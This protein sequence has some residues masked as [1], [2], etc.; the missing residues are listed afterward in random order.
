MQD[1]LPQESY[2]GRSIRDIPVSSNRRTPILGM[3]SQPPRR[4]GGSSVVTKIIRSSLCA[5]ILAA[6][7]ASFFSGAT[8][9]ISVKE[10][11]LTLPTTLQA[12]LQTSNS[13]TSLPYQLVSVS[14]RAQRIVSA[15]GST[16]VSSTAQGTITIFNTGKTSPQTLIATTRFATADGKIYRIKKSVTVPAAI[17]DITGIIKPSTAQATVV[18]DKAGANY[19]IK[20][21]HL[22]IPGFNG[23]PNAKLFYAQSG[24][25]LGGFSG[26]RPAL[27]PSDLQ[28]AQADINKEL[29]GAL[30]TSTT[31]STSDSVVPITG[32]VTLSVSDFS[33]SDAGNG[34]ALIVQTATST[35]A[36]VNKSD[37]AP[38]LAHNQVTGYASEPVNFDA[39]SVLTLSTTN[40]SSSAHDLTITVDGT[41]KL[42][43]QFDVTKIQQALVGQNKNT[44]DKTMS[45][46]APAIT[47]AN[48]SLTPIWNTTFPTDS[49]KIKINITSI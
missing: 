16:T 49:T 48:A 10:A 33:V 38:T 22:T 1:I 21:T 20:D 34:K 31:F 9:S 40:Y 17:K 44:F 29:T 13:S 8:V 45:L 4:R 6:V 27:S 18:A 5:A 24:D 30:S 2:E 12:Q 28:K 25:I 7:I 23:S 37:L 46:F 47:K 3:Q 19:N 36:V 39:A 43:W 32:T 14:K 11:S 35:E 42:I 41:S 26:T 15:S